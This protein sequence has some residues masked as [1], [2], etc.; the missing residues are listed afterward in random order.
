MSAI[1][2]RIFKDRFVSM[3]SYSIG[4]I[5]LVLLYVAM[6]PSIQESQASVTPTI[7]ASETP[8]PTAAD[9]IILPETGIRN[10]RA[11]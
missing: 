10:K 2:K 1:I 9:L 4:G 8:L 6:L 7:T 11:D 5:L 3:I